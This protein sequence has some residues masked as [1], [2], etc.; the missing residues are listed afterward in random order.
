MFLLYL[1]DERVI[2]KNNDKKIFDAC[3]RILMRG[4]RPIR[5][6][7]NREAITIMKDVAIYSPFHGCVMSD[8]VRGSWFLNKIVKN[9]S[10]LKRD[11]CIIAISPVTAGAEYDYIQDWYRRWFDNK[12]PALIYEPVALLLG[13]NIKTG[14]V[15][16]LRYSMVEFTYV[17]DGITVSY[18]WKYHDQFTKRDNHKL[19]LSSVIEKQLDAETLPDQL[20]AHVQFRLESE[21]MNIKSDLI[22]KI[23]L[24]TNKLQDKHTPILFAS[25]NNYS[26]FT[27][28]DCKTLG[29]NSLDYEYFCEAILCGLH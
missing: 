11:N 29:I 19:Q 25:F 18:W 1:T 24:I 7:E 2:I 26:L 27:L 22:S 4:D 20:R 10:F 9:K 16:S 8:P 28:D 21:K 6:L 17:K 5:I 14:I 15:I 3:P 23:K 12:Q 13:L